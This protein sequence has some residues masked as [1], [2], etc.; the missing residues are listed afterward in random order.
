MTGR[1]ANWRIFLWVVIALMT[2][3]FLWA[4]RS[5]LLPFILALVISA[6]LDPAVKKL[7]S[8]GWKK[9]STVA[10]VLIA[11]FG[12]LLILGIAL[13][14]MVTS[15]LAGLK[16]KGDKV[17]A[18]VTNP[19]PLD[20]FF[21]R[22]N[23]E[24]RVR[25]DSQ[26]DPVDEAL[27]QYSSLLSRANLPTTKRAWVAQYIEPQREQIVKAV[28]SAVKSSIGMATSLVSHLIPLIFVPLLVALILPNT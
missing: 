9:S 4:V 16:D 26:K 17:I 10:L 8:R 15:Q 7:V 20:N 28:E 13:T 21:L 2:L 14:P 27:S 3:W 24:N 6:I 11:F 1:T 22:G 18:S 19:N 5:V 25:M 23:P 12:T